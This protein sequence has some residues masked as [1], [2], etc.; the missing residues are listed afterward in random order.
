MLKIGD[1]TPTSYEEPLIDEIASCLREWHSTN[2]H[3]LLLTR[4][5]GVLENM[6][7]IVLELDLARRQLLHDVLTSQ[8]KKTVR[9]E[10]V[11]N[12]VRGNK[13]L[14]GEVIVR[15]PQQRGRLLTGED[16]AI[17]LAKLQSEMSMLESDPIQ[18]QDPVSIHNLLLE[19]KAVSGSNSGPVTLAVH[20]AS[21]SETGSLKPLSETYILDIP[22]P[23]SFSTLAHSSKLKTLFTE[24]CAADI[25]EGSGG[26]VQLY[27][28]VMVQSAESP[29]PS[30]PPVSR[31]ASSRDGVLASRSASTL[32]SVKGSVK[33]RRSVV[34]GQPKTL[35]HKDSQS[36]EKRIR[37][38]LLEQGTPL[39]AEVVRRT[40]LPKMRR[41]FVPLE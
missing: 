10:T 25:G 14:T 22:S 41:S 4:Q 2:L 8:E 31:S 6:S 34:C 37:D 5:Y 12:L 13:M 15:D 40:T 1:E 36:S 35:A 20:L 24:L 16:S 38:T 26:N 23:E 7:N 18:Q 11:W 30:L 21:K 29:R 19:I 33:G 3:E 27:L 32:N 9:Q 17:E 39:A 28:V